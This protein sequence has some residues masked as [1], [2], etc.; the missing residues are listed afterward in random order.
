[1]NSLG[2]NCRGLRNPRSVRALHDL[3]QRWAPKIVFLSETKLR[4]KRMERIRDRIGFANGLFVPSFG[5]S[6]GLA[7]LWTRETDLEIKSFGRFHIDAIITEANTNFKWRI[8]GFYGHPQTYLRQFSWDLLAF[9]R[10]QY[11]LPWIC[12]GDFNEILSTVE[13]SGGLLRP[14]CQMEK[15]RNVVN[16]CGFKD[17]GYVGPDFTWCNMKEGD[18]RMYLRLDRAFATSE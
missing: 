14:Q 4:T 17:L 18:D 6:G 8:T 16:F 7:L 3:V 11:K 12:F 1:M 13:K 10:D 2:W 9:L 15:F 5:R